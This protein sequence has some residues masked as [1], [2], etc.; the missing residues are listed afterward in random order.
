VLCLCFM[1]PVMSS[2][3][4][5][6]APPYVNACG[7]TSSCPQLLDLMPNPA[8]HI[9][10]GGFIATP[11]FALPAATHGNSYS[12]YLAAQGGAVPRTW[13]NPDGLSGTGACTGLSLNTSTGIITGTPPSAGACGGTNGFVI[14]VTDAS[15][16]F[17]GR[18]FSITIN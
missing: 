14:R 15:G 7:N 11:P 2:I 8:L 17:V 16:Q 13:S 10:T 3:G 6:A 4:N 12:C 18:A 5:A 1:T 9:T